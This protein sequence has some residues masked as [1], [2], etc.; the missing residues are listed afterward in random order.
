MPSVYQANPHFNGTGGV[1]SSSPPHLV[2]ENKWTKCH[3]FRVAFGGVV[4][5]PNKVLLGTIPIS[6]PLLRI[7]SLPSGFSNRCLLVA[8]TL[9]AVYQIK[10]TNVAASRVLYTERSR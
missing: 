9:T 2:E 6:E 4:Q 3:Q 8:L 7:V 5:V 1:D 10:P